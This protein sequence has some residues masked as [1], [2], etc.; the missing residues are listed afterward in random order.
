MGKAAF[1]HG[2]A[3]HNGHNAVHGH[4]GRNL[5]PVEGTHQWLRQGQ[6]GGFDHDV[7]GRIFA[8]EQLFHGRHEVIGHGAADAAIGE[9]HHVFLGAAFDA[10]ALEDATIDAEI[11]E[12]VDDQRDALAVGV[13]QHVPDQGCLAGTKKAGDHGGGDFCGHWRVSLKD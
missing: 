7:I 11:T 2:L 4:A 8:V 1:G 13:L 6:T 12:F 5:G 9:L 10:A 3:I